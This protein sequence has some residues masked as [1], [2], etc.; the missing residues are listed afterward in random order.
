MP[1]LRAARPCIPLFTSGTV[2]DGTD[3][4]EWW[5]GRGRL[6]ERAPEAL[7]IVFSY[8]QEF[9]NALC[10]DCRHEKEACQ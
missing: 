8:V 4:A 2:V 7:G 5:L 9:A 1:T 6:A 3:G 10:F